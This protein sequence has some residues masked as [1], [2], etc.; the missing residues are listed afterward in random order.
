MLEG[1]FAVNAVATYAAALPAA[2]TAQSVE[3]AEAELGPGWTVDGI[4]TELTRLL[5]TDRQTSKLINPALIVSDQ[6][7]EQGALLAA[8][9]DAWI[10]MYRAVQRIAFKL[11][12]PQRLLLC[13]KLYGSLSLVS[14]DVARLA[15]ES[16][17]AHIGHPIPK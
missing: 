1:K 8:S 10:P 9:P 3:P 6:L 15:G 13:V 17:L 7:I 12:A 14:Q 2:A 11:R 4:V 5:L 16:L